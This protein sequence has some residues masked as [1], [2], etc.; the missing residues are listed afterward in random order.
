M[1][2]VKGIT[3]EFRGDTTKLS[4]AINT[5]RSDAKA[6]DKELEYIN[7]GLK[8]DPKNVDLLSQ[9]MT[10]LRQAADKSKD[11]LAELKKALEQM[12]NADVDETSA[13]YRELQREITKTEAKQKSYNAELKKMEAANS[14]LG[15]AAA[16]MQSFGNK[17]TAAGEA[18]KGLSLAAAGID[19]ALAGLAYKAGAAADDLVTLSKV[20]GIS[21]TELQKYKAAA[22]LTDVSVET[23]ANSQKKMKQSMY[24]ASQG[25]GQAAKAY[26]RLGVAVTD[27]NGNLRNQDEVFAETIAAL[28]K[29]ENE[30]ERDALAMQIFGKSANEL[31]PLI[32]DAGETYARVADIFNKNGLEF[33][34]D[35]TIK[36]ANDFNDSLDEIKMTWSAALNNI[37]MQLA[38]YLAP[39]LEKVAGFLDKVAGWL[40]Q[41]SPETLAII[42]VIAGVLAGLAPV[43][44]ILGKLAF[45]ISSIM[46]LMATIGP[47][48]GGLIATAAPIVAAIAGVIAIGV[49]LYKNW[50]TIKAKA[51]EIKDW[52]VEKWTALKDGVVNAVQSLKEKVLFYW[53][54]LKLG[55]RVIADAIKEAITHPFETAFNFIATI[56]EKI[57]GLFANFNIQLPHI[58]LPHFSISPP[59]WK[60]SDLLKGSIPSLG[61]DWYKTGGI[62]NSPSVIGVGEAGPEAVIPID[63]LKQMLGEMGGVTVN[64]YG[65]AN[66]NVDELAEKVQQK[67]I[68]LQN[69]RR[70]VWA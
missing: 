44:I 61:I 16:N 25:T 31:N 39:A 66:M 55:I 29:M 2:N 57:K 30:T 6:L 14:S 59:G 17:A 34:D 8:F 5:V 54:A 52:V 23:I 50:D 37:G 15:K 69:Q 38:G 20:T 48:I 64:V 60:L 56:I 42:G 58:K 45:A 1:A 18:L 67:I 21:T 27:A 62:F 22:D 65:S 41:L 68:S 49:L 3:I 9:K 35:E 36:K 26:E 12:K 46:S 7:K 63:K 10:V 24:S 32:E 47:V 70:Q 13:E 43:L 19:A 33:V 28:G 53:E 11:N 40:S 4:K 51:I